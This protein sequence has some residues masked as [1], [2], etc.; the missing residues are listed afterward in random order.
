MKITRVET[1]RESVPL[2]RPYAIATAT[3]S[4]V[5][6]FFARIITD[7]GVTGV[8]SGSPA[9][10]ITGESVN[11]CAEALAEDRLEWLLGRDPKQLAILCREADQHM[12]TTPAARA[13]IDI[14]LH[15]L[16]AKILDKPLV[17]LFGPCHDNLPTS[18]TIGIKN[19]TETLQEADEYLGRG[20]DCLKIKL[21]H[22]LEEDIE[23]IVRLREH[24]DSAIHMRVDANQGYNLTETIELWR[25]LRDLN[26]ELVE[27]PMPV[28]A[29]D[30]LQHLPQSLQDVLALDE[31]LH[32]EGDAL[33]LARY[34][35][36]TWVIKLMKCGGIDSARRQ[37]A[38]AESSSKQVMWGCMDE[39][40]LSIA[41]ALH[42]A[43]ASPATRFLDLD[44]SLDLSRDPASGGFDIVDGQLQLNNRPGL[45]VTLDR[46]S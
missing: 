19:V 15:D 28:D 2:S 25:Q 31:N 39:S 40:A 36:S 33:E 10:V 14:A 46:A 38:T 3:T 27:Q 32:S 42:L 12:R 24:C 29:L 41:A 6:L 18:I 21:G 4:G 1:W 17:D 5:D 44:G 37:A 22:S 13:T 20:F 7:T 43:M 30:E 26:I 11:A 35:A 45:G 23:R 34:P 9:E 16:V 8:G